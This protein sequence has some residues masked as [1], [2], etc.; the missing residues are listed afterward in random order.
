MRFLYSPIIFVLWLLTHMG[1][2]AFDPSEVNGPVTVEVDRSKPAWIVTVTNLSAEKLSYEMMGKVPRGLGIELWDLDNKHGGIRVHAED[3]A[4]SLNIDGFPADIREIAAGQS[5]KFLLDPKSM[6]TTDDTT[7]L[8]WKR[9]RDIGYY[10][11]RVFFGMYASRLMNV[12]PAD[13]PKKPDTEKAEPAWLSD[14]LKET[15]EK[16]LTGTR[17]RHLFNAQKR[18]LVHWHRGSDR[19]DEYHVE[20]TTCAKDDFEK[21]TPWDGTKPLEIALH[22]LVTRA[23]AEAR[24]KDDTFRFSSMTIEPCEDDSAKYY[25]SIYFDSDDDDVDIEFLLNG[26]PVQTMTLRLTKE[27]YEEL[28]EF[29]I[30]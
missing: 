14:V 27:Q 10:Q 6:S 20:F 28:H 24:K 9:A 5:E 30:P 25:A 12:F 29:G 16:A 19:K 7:L 2:L 1:V 23:Q 18:S 4:K 13:K 26:A 8:Q 11:C 22:E 15:Q 17:L 3:L 21:M